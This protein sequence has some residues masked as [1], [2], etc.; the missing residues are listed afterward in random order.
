[1][2]QKRKG[3]APSRQKPQQNRK[4]KRKAPIPQQQKVK[5]REGT[6]G[7]PLNATEPSETMPRRLVVMSHGAGRCKARSPRSVNRMLSAAGSAA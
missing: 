2:I 1:M 3:E 4:Q 6:A 5:S 7:K